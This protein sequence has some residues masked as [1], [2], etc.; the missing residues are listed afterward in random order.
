[1]KTVTLHSR[2]FGAITQPSFQ[3]S[4]HAIAATSLVIDAVFM[5]RPEDLLFLFASSTCWEGVVLPLRSLLC[6]DRCA[7]PASRRARTV[8]VTVRV[9]DESDPT[10]TD[11]NK[12]RCHF[13]DFV[14]HLISCVMRSCALW[15]DSGDDENLTLDIIKLDL[16]GTPTSDPFLKCTLDAL[17]GLEFIDLRRCINLV[18]EPL[19]HLTQDTRTAVQRVLLDGCWELELSEYTTG[20]IV[21]PSTLYV[22][23]LNG[24]E[25][26]ARD[27]LEVVI[28]DPNSGYRGK[29]VRCNVFGTEPLLPGERVDRYPPYPI[30]YTIFVWETTLYNHAIGF[31]G[32]PASHIERRHL[33]RAY[34]DKY[35]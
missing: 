20:Q 6:G 10:D 26:E 14:T 25:L 27:A 3:W 15:G 18:A 9:R 7:R 12:K 13:E 4:F 19:R 24:P 29:W 33:R 30:L 22:D 5:D 8:A 35:H 23:I 11:A 32:S 31:S 17:P 1:M 2:S 34:R 16:S 21:L 28:L